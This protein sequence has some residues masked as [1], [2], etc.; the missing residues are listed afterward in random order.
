[1]EGMIEVLIEGHFALPVSKQ[2]I[3]FF[4][5]GAFANE[6]LRNRGLVFSMRFT[7]S[8]ME[9]LATLAHPAQSQAQ[10]WRHPDRCT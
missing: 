9:Q 8:R 1:M 6:T 5:Q 3:C 2:V 10:A 7:F 4:D